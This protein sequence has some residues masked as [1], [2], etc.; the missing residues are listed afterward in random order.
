M[1]TVTVGWGG[2]FTDINEVNADDSDFIFSHTIP[3]EGV[4]V[5]TAEF[6]LTTLSDPTSSV[7]HV[8]RW[9]YKKNNSSGVAIDVRCRLL[10]G[11]SEIGS[12]TRT[13]ITNAWVTAE[14][15]LTAAQADSIA[16]YGDLRLEF[17]FTSSGSGGARYG[18]ISWAEFEAP[19][20]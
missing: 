6:S 4:T 5:A 9:R 17:Q 20:V 10:Q 3:L 14:E 1:G 11:A 7:N 13:N 18:Q 2:S 16:N 19:G 8:V 15:T 12:W